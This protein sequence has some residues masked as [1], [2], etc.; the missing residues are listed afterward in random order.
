MTNL[1]HVLHL[2]DDATPGGVNRVLQHIRTCPMMARSARHSLRV[3]SRKGALPICDADMIVSHLS[4]SWRRLPALVAFRARHASKPLVHVEHSYTEAFTALNVPSK[5]RFFTM[6]RT[7][8]A[9]FDSVVAVSHAQAEWMKRR[10]LVSPDALRIIT[11][12]VD[13]QD[14]RSIEA[15]T[16]KPQVIGAI[17]RL[18]RQKGLDILIRAFQRLPNKDVSLHIHGTGPEKTELRALAAGDPRIRFFGHS[19]SPD[20]VMQSVDFVAIPSR[21]EAFGLVALE[22]RAAGRPIICSDIDGLKTSAGAEATFVAG[23]S[24]IAWEKALAAAFEANPATRSA[25]RACDCESAFASA[26][27][28]LIDHHIGFHATKSS[29]ESLTRGASVQLDNAI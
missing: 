17:G 22:A 25:E 8:L 28:R 10:R 4:L 18:H 14:F 23:H 3:V 21:W 27:S 12:V 11:P 16:R 2:V 15:A 26:W 7:S 29:A 1:P 24:E 9:L 5:L 20:R 6:L 19:D 13:L